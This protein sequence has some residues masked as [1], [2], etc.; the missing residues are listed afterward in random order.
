MNGL[1]SLMIVF[2]KLMMELANLMCGLVKDMMEMENLMIVI[3]KLMK[4]V[5]KNEGVA[6]GLSLE[7][8][9]MCIYSLVINQIRKT[10]NPSVDT[11]I[12]PN[13]DQVSIYF[14]Q[15]CL[16]ASKPIH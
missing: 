7:T 9:K 11:F 15:V 12:Y 8:P 6:K 3:N 16:F 4:D 14:Y 5:A 13:D 1:V 2:K 10:L